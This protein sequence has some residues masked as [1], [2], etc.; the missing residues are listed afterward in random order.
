M[1]KK[2]KRKKESHIAEPV[3]VTQETSESYW[4]LD[5]FLHG[6][7]GVVA[8]VVIAAA[9]YFVCGKTD[10]HRLYSSMPGLAIATYVIVIVMSLFLLSI[11]I[12]SF[13]IAKSFFP[14]KQVKQ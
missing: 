1:G 5:V 10:I 3:P 14:K 4:Q 13:L 11:A 8:L 7:T 6:M 12:S 2:Q 9:V